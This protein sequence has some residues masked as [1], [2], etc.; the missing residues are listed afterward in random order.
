MAKFYTA[1]DDGLAKFID[2]Q[3][4][5]FVASA[6]P[7][8]GERVNVSPKGYSSFSVIDSKTVAYIDYP[9]S[10]NETAR[11]IARGGMVTLMFCSFD[12]TPM[13]LRLYCKGEAI[14]LE[15]AHDIAIGMKR[16]IPPNARQ[17]ILL[18]IEEVMTSCGDGV[19]YFKYLGE[20]KP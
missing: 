6:P 20:R 3:K 4:I 7:D 16:E 2:A 17:I 14:P 8:S 1:L 12:R 13:I 10:G 15:K 9:G 19:P 5:F 18:H 11:H